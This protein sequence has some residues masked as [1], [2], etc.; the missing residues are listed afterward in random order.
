MRTIA[1][2]ILPGLA[3]LIVGSSLILIHVEPSIP[4]FGDAIWC[5]YAVVTTISFGDIVA[6]TPMGRA[7]SVILGIY[8]IVVVAVITSIIVNF[9]NETYGKRDAKEAKQLR[10]QNKHK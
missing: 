3:A 2:E 9:Y 4:R 6:V 7:V 10:E 1:T 8:G 5:C